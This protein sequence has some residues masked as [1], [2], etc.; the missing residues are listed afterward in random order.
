MANPIPS[1]EQFSDQDYKELVE[2]LQ[3]IKDVKSQTGFGKIILNF[4]DG[5]LDLLEMTILKKVKKQ[6]HSD[7]L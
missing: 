7:W 3:C 4:K 2:V 6:V 1:D 5:S